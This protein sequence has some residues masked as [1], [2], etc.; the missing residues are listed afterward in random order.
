MK[1]SSLIDFAFLAL[2]AGSLLTNSEAKAASITS[3]I[4]ENDGQAVIE[5]SGEIVEGDSQ[6][7]ASWIKYWNEKDVRVSGIRLNSR[8]GGVFEAEKIASM[9]RGANMASVIGKHHVCYS[10]CVL[11]F[12]Y[13]TEKWANTSSEIGVHSVSLNGKETLESDGITTAFVR[14]LK[15]VGAPDSVIVKTIITPPDQ[16]AYLTAD[17]VRSMGGRVL[18]PQRIN[19]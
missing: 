2:A 9:I 19:F 8:G 17:E 12:A 4:T 5:L 10:A 6:K 16:I 11:I 13:G 7:I 14:D 15:S 3:R 1:S 18:G